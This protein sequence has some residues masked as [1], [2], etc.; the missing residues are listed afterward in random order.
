MSDARAPMEAEAE[1]LAER[2]Y[3]ASDPDSVNQARK[4]AGRN[5][6]NHLDFVQ[7][8]MS[9]PEGRRWVREMME[10]CRVFGNPV[11]MGDTHATYFQLGEQNVGKR[12]LQDVQNFPENYALM[13]KEG[14]TKNA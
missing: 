8:M 11:V 13:M 6:K 9:V 1:L 5:K 12:I 2:P 14:K 3:D 7:A 4:R 10:S